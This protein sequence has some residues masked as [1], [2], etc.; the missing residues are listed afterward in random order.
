M[1]M[2][3]YFRSSLKTCKI[4]PRYSWKWFRETTILWVLLWYCILPVRRGLQTIHHMPSING[5]GSSIG[6]MC[7]CL[8]VCLSVGTIMTKLLDFWHGGRPWPQLVKVVGQR[9]VKHGHCV[10]SCL[11]SEKEVNGEGHQSNV[12]VKFEYQGHRP[13]SLKN[14]KVTIRKGGHQGR[15]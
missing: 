15:C 10:S 6:P 11:L 3:I 14:I 8:S 7:V 9:S 2:D 5:R 12:K 13:R 4:D 1:M